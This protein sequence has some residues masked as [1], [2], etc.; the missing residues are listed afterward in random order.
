MASVPIENHFTWR[1]HGFYCRDDLNKEVKLIL[2]NHQDKNWVAE[3]KIVKIKKIVFQCL[4][5]MYHLH[6]VPKT[7][8]YCR[9]I[10]GKTDTNIK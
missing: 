5:M 9:K 2:D 4:S 3:T 7:T 10:K 6:R 1:L 8:D